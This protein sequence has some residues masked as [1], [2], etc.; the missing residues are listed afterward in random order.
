MR[1]TIDGAA[2]RRMIMSAAASIELNKQRVN[3]LNV[4][5]VPD[6]DTGT[7]MSM[8]LGAAAADLRKNEDPNLGKAADITAS[9]LLRGARGN[10]GVILSLLFRGFSKALKGMEQA[11][12]ANFAQALTVGVEAAY[13]AV[14]KPAEGTILTV[15][16]VTAAKAQEAAE[17]HRE[18]EYVLSVAIETAKQA[19]PQTTEQNPVLKKAG[20][21]DAGAVGFLVILEGMMASLQGHDVVSAV[22]V[23]ANTLKEQADFSEFATEDIQFGYCTEFIVSREN[24]K[25]PALL[26]SFLSSLGDSLV[27]VDDDEIIK[28]HV[29]TNNPGLAIEE[30]LTYGGLVTVKGGKYAPAAH[31]KN[32]ECR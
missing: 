2:F 11:D 22:D 6:G 31:R 14:M 10:S 21:V 19:L 26:R 25:D 29:H 15:S 30:S 24:D 18:V 8:T 5:P 1:Q 20:V 7:N 16:R 4:F 23:E 9:A 27:L 12:G 28:V 3:E 17:E 32:H 13:N